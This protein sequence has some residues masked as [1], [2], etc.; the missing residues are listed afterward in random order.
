MCRVSDSNQE[1]LA[2]KKKLE[3]TT[4]CRL[5]NPSHLF[6]RDAATYTLMQSGILRKTRL[7]K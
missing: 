6:L 5:Q 1:I 3:G 7:A 4:Q 2:V